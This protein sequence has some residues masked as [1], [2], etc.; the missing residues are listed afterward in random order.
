MQHITASALLLFVYM[1]LIS[2]IIHFYITGFIVCLLFIAAGNAHPVDNQFKREVIKVEEVKESEAYKVML[3]YCMI[4]DTGMV[5]FSA[6]IKNKKSDQ[7]Y[8]QS[9]EFQ[10]ENEEG[11]KQVPYQPFI[12]NDHNFRMRS[13]ID[14]LGK[15]KLFLRFSDKGVDNEFVIPVEIKKHETVDS[16]LWCGMSL[17]GC[18]TLH[19]LTLVD[20]HIDKACCSHCAIDAKNKLKDRVNLIETI[21]YDGGEK[22]DLTKAWFVEKSN[23]DIKN[24]MPPYIFAFASRDKAEVFK[25]KHGGNIADYKELK[26]EIRGK[27][28]SGFSTGEIDEL[29]ILE[30]MFYKIK[31]SYY[32]EINIKDLV[33]ISMRAVMKSL[34]RDS[35][36]KK[37]EPSSLDFIR[38]FDR[39][40]TVKDVDIVDGHIGYIKITYFGRRTKES[41]DKAMNQLVSRN[42]KGVIIDLRD[43]PGGSFNDAVQIMQ[44]FVPDGVELVTTKIKDKE[45]VRVADSKMKQDYP[46]AILINKGTASSAEL[47]AA[48]LRHHKK[49]VLIGENSFG[50]TTIQKAHPL[51]NEYTMFLTIGKYLLPDGKGVGKDGISPDY[52]IN[53]PDQQLLKAIKVLTDK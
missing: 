22:I 35:S 32:K 10:I 18:E 8:D 52:K 24:S 21:D 33:D 15:Y 17:A 25:N 23:L 2:L 27:D 45:I 44:Y 1:K 4:G 38:G 16:C 6:Q 31:E 34:D 3:S 29:L 47:F 14:T 20:G 13:F 49:A 48:S 19:F 40:E 53:D 51:N 26:A 50:K 28:E 12:D 41:F 11:L 46:L 39:E 7:Y 37:I 36:L 43:N 9:L 30:E 42:I 5:D